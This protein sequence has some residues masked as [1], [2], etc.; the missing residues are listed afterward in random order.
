MYII[1]GI[2][3]KE[4][5][6]SGVY[7][8]CGKPKRAKPF[9]VIAPIRPS[10]LLLVKVSHMDKPNISK[11]RKWSLSAVDRIAVGQS[12]S[13]VRLFVIPWTAAC[14]ASWV[15]SLGWEDP[16]RREWLTTPIF[17]PGE[18]HGQR[19]LK[20]YHPWELQRIGH[21]WAIKFHFLRQ[22]ILLKMLN[23]IHNWAELK[24]KKLYPHVSHII[25][26]K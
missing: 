16:W 2:R 11:T 22:D 21:D 3:L 17:L 25:H 14:Q 12:M 10:D 13:P 19:S 4:Q 20:G 8:A 15:R 24:K 1:L 7:Y 5:R 18:S 26:R 6:L 23:F 9:H